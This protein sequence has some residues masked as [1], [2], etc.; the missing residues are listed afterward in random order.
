MGK[1]ANEE[2]ERKPSKRRRKSRGTADWAVA[3][4]AKVL[5]AL[6][7]VAATGGALRFGYTADGGAFAIG[8]YG[9]GD[10]YTDYVKPAEDINQYLH[11]LA[12]EWE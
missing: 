3:D 9:D 7:V 6:C 1:D 8:V 11:D 2:R 10:P 5:R 4:G 12:E